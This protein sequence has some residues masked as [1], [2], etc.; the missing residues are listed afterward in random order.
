MA[1]VN[2]IILAVVCVLV[3]VAALAGVVMLLW[4]HPHRIAEA[5]PA[6]KENHGVRDPL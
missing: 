1:H 4:R 6:D 5:H 3:A 2:A